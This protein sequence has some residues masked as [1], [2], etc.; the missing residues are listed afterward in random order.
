MVSH[1]DEYK[2]YLAERRIDSKGFKE[3]DWSSNDA[4]NF[5]HHAEEDQSAE[6]AQISQD[7]FMK[8]SRR[9]HIEEFQLQEKQ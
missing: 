2:K 5:P 9:P 6:N 8:D 4:Q 1:G 7:K 3:R